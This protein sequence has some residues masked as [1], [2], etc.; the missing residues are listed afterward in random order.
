[1]LV[2]SQSDVEEGACNK[3]I[4]TAQRLD[5]ATIALS[6]KTVAWATDE[7]CWATFGRR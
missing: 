4:S 6:L 1:M 5:S 7:S 3:Q 2:D